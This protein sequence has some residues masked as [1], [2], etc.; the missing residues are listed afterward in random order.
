MRYPELSKP[1]STRTV[2]GSSNMTSLIWPENMNVVGYWLYDLA[3]HENV[4]ILF[5]K[6]QNK[7]INQRKK[8]VFT[9]SRKRYSMHKRKRIFININL[10]TRKVWIQ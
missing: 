8:K 7:S 6:E 5:K 1:P 2:T 10:L 3:E 9:G 4:K